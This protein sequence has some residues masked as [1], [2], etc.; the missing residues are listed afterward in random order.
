MSWNLG[1]CEEKFLYSELCVD[2]MDDPKLPVKNGL[3]GPRSIRKGWAKLKRPIDDTCPVCGG[4]KI[5]FVDGQDYG[6]EW[7]DPTHYYFTLG[8]PD[9]YAFFTETWKV[10]VPWAGE[11]SDY[12]GVDDEW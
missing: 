11:D 2:G 5:Y 6:A 4:K 10:A 3:V 12:W 8:C 1:M 9:C 7:D